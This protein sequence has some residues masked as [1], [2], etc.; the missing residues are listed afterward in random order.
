MTG[1]V[2]LAIVASQRTK[3]V[4]PFSFNLRFS[5]KAGQFGSEVSQPLQAVPESTYDDAFD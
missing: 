3:R 5:L 2:T 4:V 1:L